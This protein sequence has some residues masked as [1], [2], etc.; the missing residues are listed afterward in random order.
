MRRAPLLVLLYVGAPLYAGEKPLWE[1]EDLGKPPKVE[2]LDQR[3]NATNN[4]RCS[5][6]TE[7]NQP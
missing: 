5:S 6:E 3:N 2:W 7:R 1:V 4:T